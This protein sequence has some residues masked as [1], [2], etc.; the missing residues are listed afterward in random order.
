MIVQFKT[1]VLY[2]YLQL[3]FKIFFSLVNTLRDTLKNVFRTLHIM[4]IINA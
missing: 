1:C 2:G 4:G 3:L